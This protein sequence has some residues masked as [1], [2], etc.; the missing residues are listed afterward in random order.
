MS[1]TSVL[2][3]IL[4]LLPS[5]AA[6]GD[7]PQIA[8]ALIREGFVHVSATVRDAQLTV[9][10]ENRHHRSEAAALA[11]VLRR[12]HPLSAGTDS[13]HLHLM[14]DRATMLV[15]HTS[16]ADLGALLGGSL[17]YTGWRRRIRVENTT[18]DAHGNVLND[19]PRRGFAG[20]DLLIGAG[21]RYQLGNY[22]S[23]SDNY[24]VALDLQPELRI[25]L[26]LGLQASAR[27]AIPTWNNFDDQVDPRLSRLSLH[28]FFRTRDGLFGQLG[29][30]FYPQNRAG[31]QLQLRQYL[32]DERLSL[33]LDV[34]HTRYTPL[35]GTPVF[36]RA[37]RQEYTTYFGGGTLRVPR[38]NLD[39]SARYG[40][41]LY[42]DQGLR[43]DIERQFGQGRVGFF[44]LETK[45]GRNGGFYMGIPIPPAKGFSRR[46]IRIRTAPTIDIPYR[47]EGNDLAGRD[48]D[49]ETPIFLKIQQFY[50]EFLFY[51]L[52]WYIR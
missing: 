51:E 47:Y 3:L 21:V 52:E 45:Q 46:G 23:R 33:F 5:L 19:P 30:G 29:A 8:D 12:L 31:V 39:M 49:G 44:L 28:R 27:A 41:F 1:K 38:L 4:V 37:A 48:L 36:L 9:R 13:L 50:P 32:P 11:V 18:L 16:T 24:R 10:Y 14:H 2:I 7:Q 40:R 6:A 26:P 43:L 22:G 20:I 42:D 34:S 15:L 25:D 17:P 35:T